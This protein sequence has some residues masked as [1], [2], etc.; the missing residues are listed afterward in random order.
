MAA[1][2]ARVHGAPV[3]RRIEEVLG[4]QPAHVWARPERPAR[5]AMLRRAHDLIER[6]CAPD[7]EPALLHGDFR[8]TTLLRS[9]GRLSGVVDW[10]FTGRGPRAYDVASCRA[11]MVVLFGVRADERVLAHYRPRADLPPRDLALWDLYAGLIALEHVGAWLV[12][13]GEQ[14]ATVPPGVARSRL[15]AFTGRALSLCLAPGFEATG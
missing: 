11:D 13:Y 14:G 9:R 5:S 2:L 10:C 7:A 6:A 15:L 4:P 12:A 8:P 3:D 1:V